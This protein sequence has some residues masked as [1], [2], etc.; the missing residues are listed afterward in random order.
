MRKGYCLILCSL[1]VLFACS[2]D[3]EEEVPRW[4]GELPVSE[5][6]LRDQLPEGILAYHRIPNLLGVVTAPK[7]NVLDAALG[8]EANVRNV[9]SI[10]KGVSENILDSL[11]MFDDIRARV[12]LEKIRSPIEI[13]AFGP[14]QYSALTAVTLDVDS[15]ESFQD[16]MRELSEVQPS[17][18]LSEPLDASGVGQLEGLPAPTFL[19]F[20]ASSGRLVMQTGANVTAETFTQVVDSLEPG[21]THPMHALEEMIDESGQGWFAW[22]ETKTTFSMAQLFIPIDITERIREMGLD[23]TRSVAFGGGVANG[24]GR[25]SIVLDIGEELDKRFFPLVNNKLNAISVGEPD[26]VVL[27]S[28][29]TVEEFARIEALVLDT[30]SAEKKQDW[31]AEKTEFEEF[32]G[33]SV[34][35]L[36]AAVGPEIAL[37][38]DAAGDYLAIRLRDPSLFDSIVERLSEK[39]QRKPVTHK[40]HGETF[41]YWNLPSF[42]S[43]IDPEEFDDAADFG[44]LLTRQREHWYWMRDGDFLYASTIPQP[45]MDRVRMG[46]DTD[47][48]EWLAETQRVDMS[49]SVFALSGSVHKVPMRVYHLYIEMMQYV[50][51]FGVAEYDAWSM[52]TAGQLGLPDKGTLGFTLNLGDPYLSLE[53]TFESSPGEFL[54]GGGF[55]SIATVGI[56]AA[57]AIPAYQD[58]ALRAKVAGG[59]FTAGATKAAVV[60]HYLAA[61]QFPDEA[62]ALLL[63]QYDTGDYVRSVTV[64][65]GTGV[66][67]VEYDDEEIPYGGEIYLEPSVNEYDEI[68]WTCS[69][70]LEEKYLPSA[71]RGNELPELLEEA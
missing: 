43:A 42:Y 5:P 58:Y 36:F 27:F 45:L 64:E 56:L 23:G 50:A 16:M 67:V 46:P 2:K 48:S 69:G 63:N 70:T 15:V 59:M 61:G 18:K 49:S 37:I 4:E 10:Q 11:P 52:P 66:I 22:L 26:G 53:L 41:Y 8:S 33:I 31:V 60:E 9:L 47:V 12:V 38:L 3:R 71:C 25:L 21:T 6:W 14:P 68:V 30:M 40:A 32:A 35:E 28:I 7:G 44:T 57:I 13:A 29:P 54:V 62:A 1:L 19:K 24:K 65:P 39:T 17:I 34:D 55:A 51:D 20:D